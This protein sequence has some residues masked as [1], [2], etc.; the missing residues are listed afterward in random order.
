MTAV[1]GFS[2]EDLLSC[3]DRE[4]RYRER[5]FPRRVSRGD[6]TIAE[7]LRERRM[8]QAIRKLVEALPETQGQ[9]FAGGRR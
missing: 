1:D 9:L 8:M 7:S 5:V 4:L 6:M 2:R 3:L